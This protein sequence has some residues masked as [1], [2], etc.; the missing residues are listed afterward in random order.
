MKATRSSRVSISSTVS[1]T[2]M[3]QNPRD[4]PGLPTARATSSRSA[5]DGCPAAGDPPAQARRGR[6][7]RATSQLRARPAEA[8]RRAHAR[9]SL[10]CQSTV[11]ETGDVGAEAHAAQPQ[12]QRPAREIRAAR[13]E[14]AAAQPDARRRGDQRVARDRVGDGLGRAPGRA[15]V[16]G[17]RLVAGSPAPASGAAGDV[18][19][20]ASTRCSGGFSAAHSLP[21]TRVV[22]TKRR[23]MPAAQPSQSTSAV[24]WPWFGDDDERAVREA[25]GDAARTDQRGALIE[26]AV[27]HE[28]RQRRVGGARRTRRIGRVRRRAASARTSRSSRG[29]RRTRSPCRTARRRSSGS[30]AEARPRAAR[31]AAAARPARSKSCG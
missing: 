10:R 20:N 30:F 4:S 18:R 12:R 24:T 9:R 29:R 15:P 7:S 21:L 3:G 1:C 2:V 31:G 5:S 13:A 26:V 27:E 22:A 14:A 11:P 25:R 23:T 28:R 6:A 19:G 17:E 8:D 16:H